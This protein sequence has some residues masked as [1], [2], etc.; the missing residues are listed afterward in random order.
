[1]P[2]TRMTML[3]GCIAIGGIP[4]LAGFFSKDE[5]LWSAYKIGGYGPVVWGIAV[6]T[7]AMTA[8]YMFRLY[9]MTFSG[10]FR[11]TPEQAAHVHES[12]KSMTVPLMILAAG[13]MVV[14]FLGIPHV[15]DPKHRVG[16]KFEHFTEPAFETSKAAYAQVFTHVSHDTSLEIGLMVFSVVI[17]LAGILLARY[18]YRTNPAVPERLEASLRPAHRLLLNKYYVD[19]IYNRLFV[20]GLALGGGTALWGV[21]RHFIDG[22]DGKVK[23]APGVNGAV[24]LTAFVLDS[25]SYIFR[26][27]QN[28][29]IQQYALVMLMGVFLIIFAGRFV[30]GLY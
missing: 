25:G 4:P 6:V 13:S 22:G 12:P 11:G 19:Q 3:I 18:F 20:R 30:F 8:F 27:V 16:N 15:L 23:P 5:I 9:H 29:L 14:G 1:M 26:A 7:A 17:A 21:D 24:N 2:I 28:G 10:S